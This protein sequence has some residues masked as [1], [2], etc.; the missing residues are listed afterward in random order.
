MITNRTPIPG[1]AGRTG[2]TALAVSII[3][4]ATG[5]A[6]AT[7]CVRLTS[8]ASVGEVLRTRVQTEFGS[9]ASVADWNAIR[10]QFNGNLAAFYAGRPLLTPVT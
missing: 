9:G 6:Q 5:L 2:R 1:P 7:L 8:P 4:L 3:L 10:D